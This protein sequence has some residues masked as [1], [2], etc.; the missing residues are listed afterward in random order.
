[1]HGTGGRSSPQSLFAHPI[2][3]SQ[4]GV[5]RPPFAPARPVWDACR[6]GTGRVARIFRLEGTGLD[7]GRRRTLRWMCVL[8][9]TNQLGFGAIVPVVP[10]YA[11]DYGVSQAAVG[12]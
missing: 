9:A 4:P 7:A 3:P 12:L 1:M 5:V 2:R 11:E 6:W 8:I 10:L